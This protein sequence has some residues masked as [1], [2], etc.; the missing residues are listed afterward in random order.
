MNKLS[1]F[2]PLLLLILSGCFKTSDNFEEPIHETYESS[3]K[4]NSKPFTATVNFE[5]DLPDFETCDDDAVRLGFTHSGNATHMGLIS[6]SFSHCIDDIFN[7]KSAFN[8]LGTWIA[9]N[10]AEVYFEYD[11]LIEVDSNTGQS[12]VEGLYTIIGGTG[13]FSGAAG[14][15]TFSG[16]QDLTTANF[17]GMAVASGTIVY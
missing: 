11:L 5:I 1:L 7:P 17:A 4:A 10:G 12:S 13:R 16:T 2:I 9:A 14:N 3:K 8:G 6:G 15:G